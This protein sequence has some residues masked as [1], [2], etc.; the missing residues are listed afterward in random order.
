[1]SERI[2]KQILLVEDDLD[3][4]EMVVAF[5]KQKKIK[6]IHYSEPL[7][8]LKDF[9]NK[10]VDVDAIISD[11]NM[12][13]L[14]G[15]EL[16]KKLREEGS[17]VPVILITVSDGVDIAVEAIEAGAYDFV[18]KPLH[19]P[20]L[21]ISAQRAF[22]MNQLS[23]ENKTL[24]TAI[25]VTRGMNPEGIIGFSE[26]FK[27]FYD[28]A[29]RVANSNSTILI[30]GES[31]SGK[32]VFAKAIHAWSPR[33]DKPFVAINCSAIPDNLL[34]S[35]LFGHSKGAFTGAV[36]KKI[37]LF[38][39]AEGGTLFLDEI[40]DMNFHLQAKL[41][42]VIQE[43]KIKR[44]GENQNRTI[45]VRVITATHKDLKTEVKEKRFREDLYFRLNVIPIRVPALR[46]RKE[47]IIPLANF[48]LSK[49]NALNGTDIKGF[50]PSAIEFLL[51]KPWKGNVRELENTIERSVVLC[52][53]KEID[54]SLFLAFDESNNSTEPVGEEKN[55]SFTLK[56]GEKFL[57][58]DEIE[59][60]YIHHVFEKNNYA[61][62]STA[63][64]L[65][66]DRKTLY[67]K[68]LD[69]GVNIN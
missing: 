30:S 49:F 53:T 66:I 29:R 6:I 18:V 36:D 8:A 20:Q 5:F 62:E 25:G 41:L 27:K 58:L 45:D 28:L 50:T 40:G 7:K 55:N 17:Q 38:E 23:D 61:R 32:E 12:P 42:R 54:V 37:G 69:I 39:E 2:G 47:D 16:I 14:S 4:A 22:R 13:E 68:L 1:M 31:G 67:R 60:K 33:K 51:K 19:F 44:V 24:K 15:L 52:T 35:E 63:K 65:G 34:E 57:P 21:Y 9:L 11:L 10:K 48:F 46:E 43:R 64:V 26:V 56:Y 59:K 3:L